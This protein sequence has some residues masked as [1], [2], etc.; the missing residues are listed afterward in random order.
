M[1]M[2]IV[3]KHAVAAALLSLAAVYG[4]EMTEYSGVIEIRGEHAVLV[5]DSDEEFEIR[6]TDIGS[7]R[8]YHGMIVTISGTTVQPQEEHSKLILYANRI[9]ADSCGDFALWECR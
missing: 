5:T 1:R 9:D 4:A 6:G 3:L 7:L 2:I 8:Q